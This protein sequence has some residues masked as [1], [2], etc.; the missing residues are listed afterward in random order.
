MTLVDSHCSSWKERKK[1]LEQ[2]GI[3]FGF[4]FCATICLGISPTSLN[5][6]K[7]VNSHCHI[8]KHVAHSFLGRRLLGF[9]DALIK[10]IWCV[11]CIVSSL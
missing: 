7:N 11:N 4:F 1:R 8:T 9:Q 5:L 10:T 6:P 3:V 2:G